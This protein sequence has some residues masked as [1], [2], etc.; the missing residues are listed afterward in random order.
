MKEIVA[1]LK[2]KGY[3]QAIFAPT[4]ELAGRVTDRTSVAARLEQ[5][6][7]NFRGWD[8]PHVDPNR[9]VI[10]DAKSVWQKTEWRYFHELWCAFPSGQ[11]LHVA[12]MRTDYGADLQVSPMEEVQAGELVLGIGDALWRMTEFVHFASRYAGMIC[13]GESLR[14]V[15]EVGGLRN[16]RLV[17]DDPGRG[18]TSTRYVCHSADPEI[19]ETTV[20][21]GESVAALSGRAR[22]L[23]MKLYERFGFGTSDRL[24]QGWQE[25]LIY[26]PRS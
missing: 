15:M 17:V 24:L 23:A 22:G 9:D 2:S 12:G 19:L 18:S 8:Y 26:Y 16:R 7:V 20:E 1:A 13:P 21:A 5:V 3:W 11:L 25:Q 10:I 4:I 6:A 14:A